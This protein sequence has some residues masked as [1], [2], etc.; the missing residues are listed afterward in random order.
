MDKCK[1]ENTGVGKDIRQKIHMGSL[2]FHEFQV[3][4][5]LLYLLTGSGGSYKA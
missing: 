5:A 1:W 3:E 4:G 2:K